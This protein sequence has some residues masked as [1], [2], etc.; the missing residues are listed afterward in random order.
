MKIC[1]KKVSLRTKN[2][3][4]TCSYKKQDEDTDLNKSI[5]LNHIFAL[6]TV[7]K[8]TSRMNMFSLI[9]AK[10]TILEKKIK[11]KFFYKKK[12]FDYVSMK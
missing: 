12:N 6:K 1:C 9:N 10:L 11:S 5:Y 2:F 4:D 7:N 3:V 8:A